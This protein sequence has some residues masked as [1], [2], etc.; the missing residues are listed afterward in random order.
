MF[1]KTRLIKGSNFTIISNAT[2]TGRVKKSITNGVLL[3]K[4]TSL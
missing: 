1:S 4:I 3:P 2:V